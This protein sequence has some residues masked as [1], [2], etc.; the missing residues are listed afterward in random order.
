MRTA[1]SAR[2]RLAPPILLPAFDAD[3]GEGALLSKEVLLDDG[4]P[5]GER[6][7]LGGAVFLTGVA[8]VIPLPLPLYPLWLPP[9]LP[10]ILL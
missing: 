9:P 4:A 10:L 8:K 2:T 5:L 1:T 6:I 3:V 7:F